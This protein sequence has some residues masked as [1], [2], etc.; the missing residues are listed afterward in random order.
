[1]SIDYHYHLSP[2]GQ[3]FK[4]SHKQIV[5]CSYVILYFENSIFDNNLKIILLKLFIYLFKKKKNEILLELTATFSCKMFYN[6][7]NV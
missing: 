6:A 7:R 5:N 2:I 1:M 4:M 3:L